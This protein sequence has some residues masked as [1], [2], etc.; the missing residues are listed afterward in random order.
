VLLLPGTLLEELLLLLELLPELRLETEEEEPPVREDRLE[1]ES[2]LLVLD[3]RL[4]RELLES[5]VAELE[6]DPTLED[7]CELSELLEEATSCEQSA[8]PKKG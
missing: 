4:D 8:L 6:A 5:E 1:E 7:D 3:D 2:L